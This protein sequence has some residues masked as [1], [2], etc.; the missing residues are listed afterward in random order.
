MC[1][2]GLWALLRLTRPYMGKMVSLRAPLGFRLL[3]ANE[4]LEMF[5]WF[6]LEQEAIVPKNEIAR[7]AMVP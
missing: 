5:F 4:V 1:G 7:E 3:S 2:V 6:W